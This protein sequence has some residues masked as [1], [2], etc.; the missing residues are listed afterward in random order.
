MRRFDVHHPPTEGNHD[1]FVPSE[2]Q[3]QVIGVEDSLDLLL[4]GLTLGVVL[5]LVHLVANGVLGSVQARKVMLAML[6]GGRVKIVGS[7][8]GADGSVAVLGDLLV[9]LLAGTRGGLLDRLRDVV[10]GLL[11]GLHCDE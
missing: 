5:A 4:V 8:P 9:G 3:G 7:L 6:L 10:D 2:M 11:G 1:W